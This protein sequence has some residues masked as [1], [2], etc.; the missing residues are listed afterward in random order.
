MKGPNSKGSKLS[1]RTKSPKSSGKRVNDDPSK[2]K[3]NYKGLNRNLKD[4]ARDLNCDD[5]D[6]TLQFYT[7]LGIQQQPM[8]VNRASIIQG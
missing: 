1:D 2:P 3:S 8:A 7:T 4:L 5:D 6:P